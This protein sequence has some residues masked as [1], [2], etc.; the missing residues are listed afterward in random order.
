MINSLNVQYDF[1][2]KGQYMQYFPGLFYSGRLGSQAQIQGTQVLQCPILSEL[3]F[4]N[5]L[6]ARSLLTKLTG[7]MLSAIIS[8]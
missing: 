8:S 6:Y 2:V 3:T 1:L 4:S 7:F 5:L